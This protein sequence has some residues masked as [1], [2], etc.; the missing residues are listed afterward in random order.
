MAHLKSL[1]VK[2]TKMTPVQAEYLGLP[3]DGPFKAERR[4]EREKWKPID[5]RERPGT[6]PLSSGLQTPARFRLLSLVSP[7]GS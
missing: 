3:V 5:K 4:H 6:K 2:L 1:N 7:L